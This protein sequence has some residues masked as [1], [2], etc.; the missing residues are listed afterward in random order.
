MK[1]FSVV[2]RIPPLIG[3]SVGDKAL[4]SFLKGLN[5]WWQVT[6]T[7]WYVSVNDT[8]MTPLSL[9][10]QLEKLAPNGTRIVVLETTRNWAANYPEGS[11]ELEWLR[12]AVAP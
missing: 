9:T 6:P 3:L 4:Q 7:T 11:T 5:A 8:E 12:R 1:I 10:E 2:Y